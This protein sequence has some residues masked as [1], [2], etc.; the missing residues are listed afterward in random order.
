MNMASPA[1]IMRTMMI[2]L[3]CFFSSLKN[4]EN[5]RMNTM[6]VDLVMVYRATSIYSKL[7]WDRAMSRDATTATIPIL[8]RT[9]DQPKMR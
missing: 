7:H 6:L 5:M 2:R 8:P 9:W 3:Q 1:L 4:R